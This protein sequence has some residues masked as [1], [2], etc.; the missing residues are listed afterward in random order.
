[1]SAAWRDVRGALSWGF[2]GGFV[3]AIFW[4]T[5]DAVRRGA[6]SGPVASLD[7]D[8]LLHN[9]IIAFA[10][11]CAAGAAGF[12]YLRGLEKKEENQSP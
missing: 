4:L 7:R 10:A 12:L 1:M 6:A 9:T 11:G 5:I 8:A 2:W 3:V